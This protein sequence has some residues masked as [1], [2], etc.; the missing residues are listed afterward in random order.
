MNSVMRGALKPV[1][2]DA[3]ARQSAKAGHDDNK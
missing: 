2:A 3:S 1:L